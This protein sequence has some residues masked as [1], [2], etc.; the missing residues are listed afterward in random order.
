[1]KIAVTF[2][3]IRMSRFVMIATTTIEI[4]PSPVAVQYDVPMPK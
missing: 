4:R 3:E 2:A 1:M